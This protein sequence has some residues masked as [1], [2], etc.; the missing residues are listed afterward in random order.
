[1]CLEDLA[2]QNDDNVLDD[3]GQVE[4]CLKN[5][6]AEGKIRNLECQKVNKPENFYISHVKR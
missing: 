1:M 6:L 5:K 4:E 3:H 2:A